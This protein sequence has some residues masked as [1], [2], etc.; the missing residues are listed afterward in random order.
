MQG[1]LRRVI[2]IA[3]ASTA[4][5]FVVGVLTYSHLFGPVGPDTTPVEFVVTPDES[6]SGIASDLQSRG[7]VRNEWI[8]RLAYLSAAEGSF[9]RPGGYELS[10]SMDTWTV[11]STLGRTPYLRWI[12]IPPGLRGE[13]IGEMLADTLSWT[14]KE[15]QEWADIVSSSA[16]GYQEG[17]YYP[18][19]YLIPS[20][21]PPAE[22]AAWL[23]ERFAQAAGPYAVEAAAE[24]MKWS[25]VLVI[26]SL[27]EREAA[28]PDMKLIS[29]IIRNRLQ[30]NMALQ[31]DA[32][33]QYI[34][35]NSENGWWPVV[36]SADK[37]LDS[38]F[39]TY[40]H[41]G[42]PPHPIA[43]PALSAIDAVLHPVATSCLYYLH[44]NNG[45]IHCS[46]N[47]AGQLQNVNKY[48]K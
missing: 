26:A 38:P 43:E 42:L 29:G 15:K 44:D 9:V 1:R 14:T 20:D 16:P 35:G 10:S 13:Q 31:L 45:Q 21:Q 17:V 32:S 48:L 27:I 7:L 40:M 33:L 4:V 46:P 2:L 6:I 39:N 41:T 24:H 22:V 30:R 18:D 34:K 23:R 11:A 25:D 3:G 36:H 19:T 12:V 28:G 8:F 5:I 37:Y 47:Y